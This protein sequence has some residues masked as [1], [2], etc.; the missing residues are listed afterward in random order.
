VLC[1]P[2]HLLLPVF[3]L[4]ARTRIVAATLQ[5]LQERVPDVEQ[6]V[7]RMQK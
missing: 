5:L 2:T 6:E 1:Q 7:A 4:S 3:M